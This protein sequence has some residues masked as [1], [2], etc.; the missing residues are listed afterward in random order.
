MAIDIYSAQGPEDEGVKLDPFNFS[1][2]FASKIDRLTFHYGDQRD[3]YRLSIPIKASFD[4]LLD[5]QE[6]ANMNIYGR[7]EGSTLCMKIRLERSEDS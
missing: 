7:M 2:L 1:Y 5:A 3:T 6:N 4:A